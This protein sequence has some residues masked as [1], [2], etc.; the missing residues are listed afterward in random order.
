MIKN[1]FIFLI[2]INIIT[3]SAFAVQKTKQ[4][5]NIAK[6]LERAQEYERALIIFS[7]LYEKGNST[8]EVTGGITR[9]YYGLRRYEDLINFLNLLLK[10]DPKR[11]N[12]KIDLGRAYYMNDQKEEA[13]A[14]WNEVIQSR[15]QDIMKYRFTASAMAQLHL[16]DEAIEVYL[17]AIHTFKNQEMIYRDVAILYRNQ[18]N[19]KKA[20]GYLLKYYTHFKKR[21]NDLYTQIINMTADKEAMAP[22]ISEFEKYYTENHDKKAYELLGG[23]YLKNND[24]N[25]AYGVYEA[26]FKQ[27]NNM[28]HFFKFAREAELKREYYHAVKAYQQILASYPP[29]NMRLEV[30]LKLANNYYHLAKKEKD[31]YIEESLSLLEELTTNQKYMSIKIAAKEFRADLYLQY[32][33]DLDK[34]LKEYHEI[35]KL[36]NDKKVKERIQLKLARVYFLKNDLDQAISIYNRVKSKKNAVF[37][38]YNKANIFYYRGSFSQAKKIYNQALAKAGIRDSLANNI[39]GQ[40]MM[41]DQFGQNST[42]LAKYS[43]AELLGEQGR[44]SEA[45]EKFYILFIEGKPISSLAGIKSARILKQIDKTEE[46]VKVLREFIQQYPQADN[47]DEAYFLLGQ[48]ESALKRYPDAL[49]A[50]Q[51]ILEI[52]PSSFYLEKAR[53]NARIITR[54]SK[55]EA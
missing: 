6:K 35:L 39:L 9:C 8:Y 12:Y 47:S 24:L 36:Q 15:P 22:I 48:C 11:H 2:L 21:Y 14:V 23:L 51:K 25:K 38:L 49:S 40:I 3:I 37:V 5:I 32:Y 19:Y 16:F 20:A 43:N 17:K 31:Q 55:E 46:A 34:A 44:K 30:K 18:L 28:N 41:I 7:R 52:F 54:I 1:V 53:E 50:Y 29:E 27:D 4:E 45:A 13:F 26:L 33:Y 42:N 10:K